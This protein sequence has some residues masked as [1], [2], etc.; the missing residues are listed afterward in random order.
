MVKIMG[1]LPKSDLNTC[2]NYFFV[3]YTIVHCRTGSLENKQSCCEEVYIVHCRTGSLEM[4]DM[5]HV[6]PKYVHCRTGSLEMS[7]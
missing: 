2:C 6:T 5:H 1:I 7:T 3:L 4:H